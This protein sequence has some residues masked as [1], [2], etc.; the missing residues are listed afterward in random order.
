[1]TPIKRT[2]TED[3]INGTTD[4]TIHLDPR[5]NTLTSIYAMTVWGTSPPQGE[6][7]NAVTKYIKANF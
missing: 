6:I 5:D 1:M 2:F 4:V 3:F 7:F